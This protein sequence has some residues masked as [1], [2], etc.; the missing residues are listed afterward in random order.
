MVFETSGQHLG[1]FDLHGMKVFGD[2]NLAASQSR[3]TLR[4][5]E[6]PG[7][8]TVPSV[9]HGH[10]HDFTFVSCIDCLGGSTPSTSF[11]SQGHHSYSWSLFPHFALMG[12]RHFNPASDRIT[13]V[14]FSVSDA[15]L[16]FDDFDSYG[17]LFDPP[18]AVFDVI[19]KNVGDRQVPHGPKPKL[20]YF[21]GR[22]D[23]ME[24][25]VSE[26]TISVQ[27]WPIPEMGS[28]EGIRLRSL[29]KLG[30]R[31]SAPTELSACLKAISKLTQFLSLVAGRS[32]GVS[33]VQIQINGASAKDMPLL[34]HWSFAPS[35]A[36]AED[37]QDKPSFF[38]MP[39]ARI[40]HTNESAVPP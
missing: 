8:L 22:C 3:L 15:S 28:S 37:V 13:D 21:A 36:T 29:L 38:D 18:V 9:V 39:L 16:I 4:T 17:V 32:Q 31:F 34:M 20:A 35:V 1:T 25:A 11:D 24:V 6:R 30:I 12:N 2:L 14:W 10:L 23:V 7:R 26:G 40:F 27:H 33:N 5:E 19:P